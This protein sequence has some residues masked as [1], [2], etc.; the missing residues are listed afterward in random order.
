MTFKDHTPFPWKKCIIAT[1]VIILCYLLVLAALYGIVDAATNGV[2][3]TTNV[4]VISVWS[5]ALGLSLIGY[6]IYQAVRHYKIRKDEGKT[7]K[8]RKK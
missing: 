8:K 3:E 4:I 1:I 2:K 7:E 5:G 6:W